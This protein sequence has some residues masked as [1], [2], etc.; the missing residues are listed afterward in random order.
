MIQEREGIERALP[1][2]N[3]FQRIGRSSMTASVGQDQ[4]EF[5][6]EPAAAGMDPILVATC[7]AV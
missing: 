2:R 5:V 7:T 6:R 1:V 3:R 4:T